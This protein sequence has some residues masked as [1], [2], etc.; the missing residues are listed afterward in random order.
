MVYE[1]VPQ[2]FFTIFRIYVDTLKNSQFLSRWIKSRKTSLSPGEWNWW[3][4][5]TW[6]VDYLL[7]FWLKRFSIKEPSIISR[8]QV[9]SFS[10]YLS[11]LFIFYLIFSK[12]LIILDIL[13]YFTVRPLVVV[14]FFYL[15]PLNISLTL[16]A[17]K[18]NINFCCVLFLDETDARG[19]S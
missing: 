9:F 5:S 12:H 6:T 18:Y 19:T 17:Y 16:N 4:I 2:T 15:A 7:S 13:G 3:R 14:H 10:N 8:Y 11:S 1:F